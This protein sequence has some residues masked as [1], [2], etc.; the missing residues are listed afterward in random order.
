[1]FWEIS[2]RDPFNLVEKLHLYALL[3]R[4]LFYILVDLFTGLNYDTKNLWL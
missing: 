4:I 2:Q 3:I 1:M